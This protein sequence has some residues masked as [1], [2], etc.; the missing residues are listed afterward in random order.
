MRVQY[1]DVK[2]RHVFE[3]MMM[4]CLEK[5]PTARG[6]FEDVLEDTH[7]LLRKYG[8]SNQTETLEG[9]KVRL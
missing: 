5:R 8:K 9:T 6:T 4:R 7:A 1:I 3:A 2:Q